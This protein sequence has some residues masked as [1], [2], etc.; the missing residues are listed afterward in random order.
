MARKVRI[1]VSVF[2][3]VLTVVMCVLWVRS[4]WRMDWV[5]IHFGGSGVSAA[6]LTGAIVFNFQKQF[7]PHREIRLWSRQIPAEDAER[8]SALTFLWNLDINL[9]VFVVPH[10]FLAAIV[11]LGAALLPIRF[12]LRTLLI[13]TTLVAVVLGLAVWAGR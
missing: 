4:Y 10:W 13:V 3:G 8:Y 5:T 9:F 7:V 12:S 2:V 11:A 1:A 6:S